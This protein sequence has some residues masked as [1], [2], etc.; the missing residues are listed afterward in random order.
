[1]KSLS[2]NEGFDGNLRSYLASAAKGSLLRL[3]SEL[4]SA[5][6]ENVRLVKT[7]EDISFSLAESTKTTTEYRASL[8]LASEVQ[9]LAE[10]KATELDQQLGHQNKALQRSQQELC[11]LN[12]KLDALQL[13]KTIENG[14]RHQVVK[15]LQCLRQSLDLNS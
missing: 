6:A 11:E 15:K 10:R 9:A 2:E 1:M 13:D 14:K 4:S 5:K 12:A 7:I 8:Q 3:R